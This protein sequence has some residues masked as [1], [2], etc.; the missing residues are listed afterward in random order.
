VSS[1]GPPGDILSSVLEKS[2]YLVLLRQPMPPSRR[3]WLACEAREVFRTASGSP[4]PARSQW[5][6]SPAGKVVRA[7]LERV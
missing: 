7:W 2:E 3:P 4:Q 1:R 5:W 6:C